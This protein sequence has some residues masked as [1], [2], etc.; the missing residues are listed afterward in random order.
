MAE[1]S[2][3]PFSAVV[4]YQ[5]GALRTVTAE[6]TWSVDPETL[7]AVDHGLVTTH[8]LTGSS[9]VLTLRAQYVE[10]DVPLA[11]VKSVVCRSPALPHEDPRAWPMY[12]ANPGH[13]GHV[14]VSL[15]PNEASLRWQRTLSSFWAGVNPVTGA[16]GKVFASL[17]V[18]L[19]KR[20]V[21][22]RP[23]RDDRDH[24][25]VPVI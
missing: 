11:A 12:Q 4:R 14:A 24:P 5:N 21:P 23:R 15:R 22:V 25:V 8:A 19:R 10:G 3:T 17:D 13:T 20:A 2:S 1:Q 18:T 16:G 7:A 9:Q 6:A